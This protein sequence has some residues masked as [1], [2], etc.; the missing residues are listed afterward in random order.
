MKIFGSIV[1]A[2]TLFFSMAAD[3]RSDLSMSD[4][5]KA[6]DANH[7][8]WYLS[9]YLDAMGYANVTLESA[10]QPRLYCPPGKLALTASNLKQIVDRFYEVHEARLKAVME[11]GIVFGPVALFALQEAFPCK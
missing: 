6:K 5:L 8:E 1:L 7:I 4:Y 3:V 9:G 10:K 2:F 11:A